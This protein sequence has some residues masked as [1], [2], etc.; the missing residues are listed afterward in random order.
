MRERKL[1][2]RWAT[3]LRVAGLC[4]LTSP[5]LVLT[6]LVVS[7]Y[8][9]P[10]FSW[11]QTNLSVLGIEGPASTLFNASLISGGALSIAF[12][13]GLGR[14]LPSGRLL[15]RLGIL[16]LILGSCAMCTIGIFPLSTGAPHNYASVVFFSLIPLSLLLIGVTLATSSEKAAGFFTLICGVLIIVPQLIPWPWSGHAIPQLLSGIPWS[17]WL[18]VFGIKLLIT[19]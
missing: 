9:F 16:T 18:V 7:V 17:V 8:Y 13:I 1:T 11:T 6:P 4:G 12:A 5:I 2:S 15:G 3:L 14:V 19:S 10:S